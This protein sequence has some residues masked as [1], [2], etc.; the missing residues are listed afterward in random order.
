MILYLI[1]QA[2]LASFFCCMIQRYIVNNQ[3]LFSCC[4]YCGHSLKWYDKI[5]LFSYLLLKGKCRYCKETINYRYFLY[6]LISILICILIYYNQKIFD[7]YLLMI[8]YHCLFVIAYLDYRKQLIYYFPLLILLIVSIIYNFNNLGISLLYSI[9]LWMMIKVCLLINKNGFGEGDK[10]L[11]FVLGFLLQEDSLVMILIA[12]LIA[13][14][15]AYILV[16]LL[17]YNKNHKIAFAPFLVIG[18]LIMLWL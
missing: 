5:P 13:G 17:G 7:A 18:T 1:I 15:L 4:D 14:L 2:C 11:C 16:Y 12:T 3:N 9:I 10:D 6:E 8:I